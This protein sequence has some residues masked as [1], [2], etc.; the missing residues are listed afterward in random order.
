MV[1]IRDIKIG[2]EKP[3]ITVPIYGKTEQ[4]V[5][6][7]AR[8]A[9]R[10]PADIIEWHADDF[11]SWQDDA[12]VLRA[13]KMIRM[14]IESKVFLF[15]FRTSDEGG[16]LKVK[17]DEYIHILK[18]AMDSRLIDLLD[19]EC[20][21]SE[22]RATEIISYAKQKNVPVIGSNYA[23]EKVLS[24]GEMDFRI[25]YMQRL[26]VDI[27]KIVVIPD[28]KKDIYR[29]LNATYDLSEDLDLPI[30]VIGKGDD[31]KYTRVLCELFG[32][33]ITYGTLDPSENPGEIDVWK[34]ASM[35]DSLHEM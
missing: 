27:A 33:A 23:Y 15:T 16:T 19:V 20:C 5:V 6:E 26:G 3:K 31:G 8:R 29:I 24:V 2:Q 35:I 9:F 10:S 22:Y 32:T 18:L 4:V 34:L 14:N 1:E 11:E 28:R 30:S 13:L 7:N 25:R 12:S 21:V 17:D